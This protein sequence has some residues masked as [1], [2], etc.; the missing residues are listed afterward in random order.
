MAVFPRI[1]DDKLPGSIIQRTVYV[2]L[3]L[4]GILT[5]LVESSTS[6]FC[7]GLGYSKQVAFSACGVMTREVVGWFET[8]CVEETA[9]F[10]MQVGFDTKCNKVWCLEDLHLR[11]IHVVHGTSSD[12]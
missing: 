9:T 10:S 11:D 7:F 3:C 6:S 2:T 5:R 1:K 8:G 4:S 12:N